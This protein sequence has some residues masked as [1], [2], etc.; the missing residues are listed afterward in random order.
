[1]VRGCL[2]WPDAVA[3]N[4]AVVAPLTDLRAGVATGRSDRWLTALTDRATEHLT[5]N[6]LDLVWLRF[7]RV[8][9]GPS[10]RVTVI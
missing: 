10:L 7:G 1:V 5:S 4:L 8:D 3:A 6:F 9:F 2:Y